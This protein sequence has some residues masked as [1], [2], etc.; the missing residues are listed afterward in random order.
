MAHVHNEPTDFYEDPD[1]YSF[2]T[3][4]FFLLSRYRQQLELG[5]RD[6]FSESVVADYI[7]AKDQIFATINLVEEE[8]ALYRTIVPLLEARVRKPELVVYLQATTEVLL[9][10]IKTEIEENRLTPQNAVL[11]A[12]QRR[13]RPILLTTMTTIGGLIP[14]YL[15]GGAMW[16]PMAV[17]IM[18]G[19]VFATALTLGV[20][21]VLY[22]LGNLIFDQHWSTNTMES[23][24]LEAMQE[25]AV[26][27]TGKQYRL[28]NPYFVLATQNPIEQEGTYPLP[29]AQVDRFM[30]KVLVDYP[31]RDEER[32]ILDR[33]LDDEEI[34]VLESWV[35]EYVSLVRK[36]L[37]IMRT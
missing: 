24:L 19:L 4:I 21:P 37:A 31:G 13:L 9:D 25:R 14:L 10:R 3:Q 8:L 15:G 6:L 22:S 5:Q 18:C 17:A 26:T 33:M 12:A 16:E 27:I 34:D 29:E 32:Q 20:V 28:P 23:A 7:F 35:R 11:E 30:L 2:Q 36:A 1:A